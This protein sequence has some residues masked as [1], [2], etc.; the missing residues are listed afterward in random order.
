MLF[1]LDQ[2]KRVKHEPS[3]RQKCRRAFGQASSKKTDFTSPDFSAP[4]GDRSMN[5]SNIFACSLKSRDCDL[6][7]HL[8][9]QLTITPPSNIW[10]GVILS[11]LRSTDV[12]IHCR[13]FLRV[14]VFSVCRPHEQEYLKKSLKI[15]KEETSQFPCIWL[16]LS[17]YCRCPTKPP[18]FAWNQK[19]EGSWLY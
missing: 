19:I 17:F 11:V 5:K 3:I 14:E 16:E 2:G 4:W 18:L 13:E 1:Y 8:N 6:V 15:I 12:S 10:Q 7:S 9:D